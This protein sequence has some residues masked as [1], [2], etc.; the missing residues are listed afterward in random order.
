MLSTTFTIRK[1]YIIKPT[2]LKE[3]RYLES[4]SHEI[5]NFKMFTFKIS[6]GFAFQVAFCAFVLLMWWG[7]I[8]LGEI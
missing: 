8:M 7:L 1:S 4:A 5:P 2:D 3:W 6:F